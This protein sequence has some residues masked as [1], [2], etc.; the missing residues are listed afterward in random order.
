MGLREIARVRCQV[1]A[2]EQLP[3]QPQ[4]RATAFYADRA[5]NSTS[6]PFKRGAVRPKLLEAAALIGKDRI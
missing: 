2:S 5:A 4:P 6:H 1:S 3:L